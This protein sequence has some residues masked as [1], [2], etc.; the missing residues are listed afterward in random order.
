[1]YRVV[2]KAEAKT[3]P[4]KPTRRW[5]DNIKVDLQEIGLGRGLHSSG[6]LL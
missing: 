5:E 4:G 6:W 3:P 2:Q 1:V